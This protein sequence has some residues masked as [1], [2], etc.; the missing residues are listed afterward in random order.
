MSY[1]RNL[2]LSQGHK[3]FFLCFLPCMCLKYILRG[4]ERG[5]CLRGFGFCFAESFLLALSPT[6]LSPLKNAFFLLW[7]YTIRREQEYCH[8]VYFVR[9]NLVGIWIAQYLNTLSVWKKIPIFGSQRRA[10][11]L[12]PNSLATSSIMSKN[13]KNKETNKQKPPMLVKGLVSKLN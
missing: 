6:P 11:L 7:Q 1:L 3:D 13:N 4:M 8:F 12:F 5:V 2:Y 9:G 10:A